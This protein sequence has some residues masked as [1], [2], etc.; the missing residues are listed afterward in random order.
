MASADKVYPQRLLDAFEYVS[1]PF[2][3][4]DVQPKE[5]TQNW[6]PFDRWI[7]WAV[8]N[9]LPI[10]GGNLV[11]FSERSAPDWLRIWEHDFEAIRDFV[12]NHIRR[13]IGRYGHC[14]QVWDVISGIHADNC[15]SFNFEQ[16]MEL[17]RMS[18]VIAKQL[19]P[20]STVVVDLI[21]PWGEYYAGNQRTI[22]PM[23]Y[24]EMLVQSGV[25]FDAFGLQCYCGVGVEG[26]YVRDLF[27]ISSLLDRF[28][29]LGKPVHQIG[30]AH[31]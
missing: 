17:T 26:H 3:W 30:R 29:S 15:F 4:R 19:A 14:I 1:I 2:T 13:V 16:L 23:L 31:V 24:A 20:R 7:E 11:S 5:E 18:T 28:A 6:E 25:N 10:R 21:T 22:P 27:Q 12:A 8:K 9:R